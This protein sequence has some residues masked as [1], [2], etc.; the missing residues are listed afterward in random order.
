MFSRRL[1]PRVE[2]T[3]ASRRLIAGQAVAREAARKAELTSGNDPAV[4]I[5]R[6]AQHGVVD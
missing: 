5:V 6:Q 4:A 2:N 3:V 1:E